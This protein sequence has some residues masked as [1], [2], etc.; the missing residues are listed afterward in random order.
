MNIK[1]YQHAVEYLYSYI[2]SRTV[3]LFGGDAGVK[4]TQYLLELLGNPQ[5]KMQVIHIAGT[6]GKGSTAYLTSTLLKSLGFKVGL[7]V[8]PHLLDLRERFQINNQ[9]ISKDEVVETMNEIFDT[10][11]KAKET[12]W[13]RITF[14]E[15]LVAVSFYIFWKKG[16]EYAVIETGLGGLLDGTNVVKN[17][18]K[19]AIITRIGYDHQAVLGKTLVSIAQQKAGIIHNGNTVITLN[20][21]PSVLNV[22]KEKSTEKKAH[23]NILTRKH[24]IYHP[25]EIEYVSFDLYFQSLQWK[26]IQLSLHGSYQAEN[27]ALALASVYV[28]SKKNNFELNEK[29][30]RTALRQVSYAG[31]FEV[32]KNKNRYI[33]IDGAH[34]PQKM[35]AFISSL[36]A[37]FPDT[38]FDFYVAFSVGKNYKQMLK[39]IIP[40][41]QSITISTFL[42][43]GNDMKHISE[44]PQKVAKS[45]QAY[46]YSNY[47]IIK[48]KSDLLEYL[49]ATDHSTVI[50]GSLYFIASLYDD[51]KRD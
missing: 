47:R 8:S 14:F 28:L 40:I 1:N 44:D 23:L 37:L 15:M 9:L 51:I 42:L 13:G 49:R 36:K 48:N 3:F 5:E 41:A 17:P 30:T 22:I 19:I 20:Q 7:Q 25:A 35:K 43:E 33:I 32:R 11:E 50:T 21:S 16:V 26:N 45:L 2:P 38:K 24:I 10:L 46:K 6:S 18:G 12:Q 29:N 39:Y 31:R 27:C 34:N 4:R